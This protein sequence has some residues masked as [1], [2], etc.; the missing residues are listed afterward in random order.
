MAGKGALYEET[1][2]ATER[3]SR[4]LRA[5][6]SLCQFQPLL[7]YLSHTRRYPMRSYL[8][9]AGLASS[10]IAVWIVLVQVIA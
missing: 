10:L 2:Q 4:I 5:G 9:A 8:T 3:T 6:P 1:L 7:G